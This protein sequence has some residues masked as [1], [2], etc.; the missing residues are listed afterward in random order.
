MSLPGTFDARLEKG[1]STEEASRR[2]ARDGYN[3]LPSS[4]PRSNLAIALEV[5]QEPM[6]LLL[7]GSG[8]IYLLLGDLAEALFL[9]AFVLFVIGITLYQQRKTERA[10]EALRDLSSPRALVWHQRRIAQ[11][12]ALRSDVSGPSVIEIVP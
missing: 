7:L 10:L 4:K 9:L 8:L 11:R 3:E 2:L 1:L 6:F 12:L 5:V